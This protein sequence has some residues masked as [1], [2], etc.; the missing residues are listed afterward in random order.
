[1]AAS[2]GEELFA[3][4][5]RSARRAPGRQRRLASSG[6]ADRRIGRGSGARFAPGGPNRGADGRSR[7]LDE[8][9]PGTSAQRSWAVGARRPG[10]PADEGASELDRFAMEEESRRPSRGCRRLPPTPEWDARSGREFAAAPPPGERSDASSGGHPALRRSARSR[11]P[12]ARPNRRLTRSRGGSCP[13]HR[14][15]GRRHRGAPM[16]LI[17]T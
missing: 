6:R 15:R 7:F 3:C 5:G 11:R 14:S 2:I 12:S 9:H 16:G 1:M 4:W 13:L 17:S 8:S 10:S